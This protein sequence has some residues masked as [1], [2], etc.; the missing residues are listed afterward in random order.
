MIIDVEKFLF[1]GMKEDLD[2]FFEK[3]QEKGMIE[4]IPKNYKKSKD[5]PKAAQDILTSIKIL[6]K[7]THDP[8]L[9]YI[10][11]VQADEL[12]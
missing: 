4:F 10:Q 7:E 1:I 3:A 6:A 12:S 5:L 8:T 9:E 2:S 11:E